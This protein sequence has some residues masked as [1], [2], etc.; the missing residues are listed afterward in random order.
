MVDRATAMSDFDVGASDYGLRYVF[1]GMG[2][3]IV[4]A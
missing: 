3:G 4:E 2:D 1:F